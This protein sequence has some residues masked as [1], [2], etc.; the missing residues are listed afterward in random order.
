MA[1]FTHA[2]E[3]GYR[4]LETDAHATADGVVVAMHDSTLDRTTDMA[5]VVG[6]LPWSEVAKARVA[7]SQ[8]VPR[9]DD[10]LATW[11]HVRWNIDTK[12]DAVVEPLLRTIL[13]AGV[14]DRVCVTS[15]SGA[16]LARIRRLGGERICTTT[17]PIGTAALRLASV[18][19]A[20]ARL[21][22]AWSGAA[23]AQ[24]PLRQGVVPVVDDRFVRF[25]HGAGL[26][27]HVWTIDEEAQM[28]RLLDIGV[29]GIMT[30]RP[31][32]LRDVLRRRGQWEE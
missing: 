20:A 14:E 19:P 2:V 5:G 17:G 10:L 30:D 11:P 15:F 9:L 21:A 29:D 22:E 12:H 25:C 24:V 18:L 16:R 23:A 1:S 3:L 32:L 28:E 31:S 8:A 13:E 7:G 26:E 4:Y 27:V 6:D